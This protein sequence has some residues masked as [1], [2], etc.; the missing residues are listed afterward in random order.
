MRDKGSRLSLD[1]EVPEL[2]VDGIDNALNEI[3]RLEENHGARVSSQLF[4]AYSTLAYLYTY[5]A[6]KT[7]WENKV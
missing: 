2:S 3:M 7:E 5:L 6:S 1:A 4:R